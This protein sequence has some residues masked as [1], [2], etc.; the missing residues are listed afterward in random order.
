M[1]D[2][3]NSMGNAVELYFVDTLEGRAVGGV[4]LAGGH[5]HRGYR[6]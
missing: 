2:S 1:M 5:R 4:V 6:R 3:T